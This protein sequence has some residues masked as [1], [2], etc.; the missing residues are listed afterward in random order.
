MLGVAYQRGLLALD[1]DTLHWA[2]GRA[3]RRNLETNMQAFDIGRHLAINADSTPIDEPPPGYQELVADKADLL[4]KTRSARIA[5]GYRHRIE[6]TRLPVAEEARRHFALSVYDLIQYEDLTYADRY[7]SQVQAICASDE[8]ERHHAATCAA[9]YQLARLTA[10]KDEVYV[11]HLL[12]F[13]EKYRRDRVRYKIDPARGNR[14][15]YRHLNRPHLRL[16]GRDFRPNLKLGERTLK[17]IARMRFLR[18]LCAAWWHR[19][20][21]DFLAWYEDLL[22]RFTYCNA[23]EYQ[24]WVRVLSLPGK[25]AATA[26][27]EFPRWRRPKAA[28][29]S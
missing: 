19:E 5:A 29:E 18:R 11:A 26:T 3:V 21:R 2:I 20:E 23:D 13:E 15:R 25:S 7:I 12:T 22:G 17:T 28:R 16:L 8:P 4:T 14:I 24:T 1:L 9:I 10:I 6:A 27:S